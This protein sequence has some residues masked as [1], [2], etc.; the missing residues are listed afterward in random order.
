M[1]NGC[2]DI[3]HAGHVRYLSQARTLGDAL[4]VAL[5]DD[6]SVRL[7]KGEGRPLNALE[8]RAEVLA[9][10]Q[11]VDFVVAFGGIEATEVV[12]AVKP[13]VYVKGGDYSDDPRSPSFPPEGHAVLRYGGLVRV[14]PYVH[15]RSTSDLVRRLGEAGRG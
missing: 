8:D 13:A 3:L 10:L 6:A 5:N 1:T 14:L 9:A 12:A 2:F 4:A 11:A 15:G 7:L